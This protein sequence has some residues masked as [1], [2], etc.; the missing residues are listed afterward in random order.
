MHETIKAKDFPLMKDRKE[1]HLSWLD[2]HGWSR[3]YH[4]DGAKHVSCS[5]TP[6]GT[7][8]LRGW[9]YYQAADWFYR[10]YSSHQCP[11]CGT[12]VQ[13]SQRCDEDGKPD[14]EILRQVI[15]P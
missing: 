10:L 13:H 7:W 6:E 8:R 5:Y 14:G 12:M 1:A 2:Q 9:G 4:W 3:D 15:L 11:T